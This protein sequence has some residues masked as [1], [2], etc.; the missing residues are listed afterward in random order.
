MSSLFVGPRIGSGSYGS[1]YQAHWQG[2]SVAI[3]KFFVA[4]AG[5]SA[6]CPIKQEID[7][8]ESLRDKH[9]I[10]FYGQT[11]HEGQL[12]LVMEYAD[13]GTLA[14]AIKNGLLK[15]DWPNKTRIA[16][17]I[18][19]GLAYIHYKKILHRDLKSVN[20]LLTQQ[21]EVKLCDFG[22]ATVKSRSISMSTSSTKGTPR[23]MA[24]ELLTTKPK[25]STK[26]DMFAF[27]VVMWEMAADCTRPFQEQVNV[28]DVMTHVAKGKREKLPSDTPAEYRKWVE[29]CWDQDPAKRPEANEMT[30][31]TLGE[32]THDDEVV[33]GAEGSKDD[34]NVFL[35]AYSRS[36]QYSRVE[37][38]EKA[39]DVHGQSADGPKALLARANGGDLEA[40]LQLAVKYEK[41][42]GV[43]QN[44]AKAFE[45]YR[46]GAD[47]GSI[48]AQYKVG[49]CYKNGRGTPEN[50]ATAVQWLQQ[51]AEGGH[52]VA[53]ATLGSMYEDGHGVKQDYDQAAMWY[54]KSADQG[55]ATAQCNLGMM[56]QSG[57]GV[58]QDYGQA[59]EWYRKSADQGDATAQCKLG[60]LYQNGAGVKKND[61]Q[62]AMW[63]HKS[64]D[65]GDA[66]A[67]NRLGCMY[68]NGSGVEKSVAYALEWFRKSADQG[69]R[70]AQSNLGK[71]Y[72]EDKGDLH[73]DVLAVV[74][75][76]KAAEQG[77]KDAQFWLA[78]MYCKG[79]G[80]QK[81]YHIGIQWLQ[82]AAAQGHD[83][84]KEQLRIFKQ[85]V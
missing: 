66:T 11:E 64:A 70:V 25:Y 80:V 44:D 24:P 52:A 74:W 56:Y 40:L 54:R 19:R 17:E 85:S 18:A 50:Q 5:A 51:A 39:G 31:M 7:L 58:Q 1:V 79:L 34:S 76:R 78:K 60:V 29:R 68:K 10:Q 14:G 42:N 59:A 83:T 13:G 72:Q 71:I 75:F 41:G 20:V 28:K 65:Q 22:L 61:E 45:W 57:R 27:G 16:Q 77:D 35:D 49:I 69:Y 4:Q 6:V 33:D 47:M 48:E 43:E 21:R 84:A 3:K 53:Q 46:R 9:I 2:R 15:H 82:K 67:Q 23:W 81:D 38:S 26:S 62:A 36:I 30:V 8:L 63:Y 12:V 55:H 37:S 73:N 32:P